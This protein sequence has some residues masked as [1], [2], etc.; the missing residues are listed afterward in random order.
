M[1]IH[2]NELPWVEKYRPK[3]IN[4]LKNNS[5]VNKLINDCVV[6]KNIPNL[7]FYGPPGTGKT[8]MALAIC[9]E[10]FGN[11][12]D[13]VDNRVLELNAS[14]ERGIKVVR[15]KIKYF[16]KN[17]VNDRVNKTTFKIVILDEADAM[18]SETQ[19]ALRRIMEDTLRV[20]RYILI[21][22]YVS[23]IIDP[24]ISRCTKFKFKPV[25]LNVYK[26]VIQNIIIREHLKIENKKII[27][28]KLFDLSDG[29]L[30]KSIQL[31]QKINFIKKGEI[32]N[33]NIFSEISEDIEQ[34][35]F[36][37]F[38]NNILKSNY[39]QIYYLLHDLTCQGYSPNQI[40]NKLPE[41]ILNNNKFNEKQKGKLLIE[42]GN[43]DFDLN[44]GSDNF[45]QLLKFFS[46][47]NSIN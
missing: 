5:K 37:K 10:L 31:L 7:L 38:I 46:I 9:R 20:T 22:N 40:V 13:I 12:H 24:I 16:A 6:K 26:Q 15:E 39:N 8:T 28:N 19:Y 32:I 43:I 27:I 23:K 25:P 21:C 44:N 17:L 29:D 30:R 2:K 11:N 1:N 33:N 4:K 41:N 14:D 45:I 3:S 35:T 18:T 34:E 42:L 36:S 47:M